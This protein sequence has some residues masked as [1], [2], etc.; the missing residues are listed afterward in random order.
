MIG[1]SLPTGLVLSN[2]CFNYL[3]HILFCIVFG[4][5]SGA[6]TS[7]MVAV[8]L[9]DII[10]LNAF[11]KGYGIQLFFMG[12]GRIIGPPIIGKNPRIT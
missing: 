3:T 7:G 4:V 5:T 2:F 9:I 12:L 8:I 6:N 10:G 11:V 1:K